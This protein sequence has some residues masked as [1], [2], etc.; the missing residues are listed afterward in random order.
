MMPLF[1]L[2][3]AAGLGGGSGRGKG[4]QIT[5]QEIKPTSTPSRQSSASTANPSNQL[6]QSAQFKIQTAPA[7]TKHQPRCKP[8]QIQRQLDGAGPRRGCSHR[9]R[10]PMVT[11]ITS[12]PTSRRDINGVILYSYLDTRGS[13]AAVR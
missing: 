11:A 3:L 5:T 6:G 8:N 1:S 2:K 4:R 9:L 7:Q 12:P 13:T 10:R